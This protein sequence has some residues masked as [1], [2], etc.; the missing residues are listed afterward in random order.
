MQERNASAIYKARALL[1]GLDD[2]C[3]IKA[4]IPESYNIRAVSAA[5]GMSEEN[6]VL[7]ACPLA[8]G[9]C[10]SPHSLALP[11]N[12]RTFS[13]SSSLAGVGVSAAG[14]GGGGGPP[15]SAPPLNVAS[16]LGQPPHTAFPF[17][18]MNSPS[19]AAAAAMMSSPAAAA[20][21]A[22]AAAAQGLPLHLEPRPPS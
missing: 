6:R 13:S 8:H 14:G 17:P 16:P 2:E 15:L 1:L 3:A 12:H 21:A 19:A 10:F 11:V 22:V 4:E 18:K 5:T 9:F 7:L 20:A